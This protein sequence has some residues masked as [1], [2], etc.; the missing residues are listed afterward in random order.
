MIDLLIEAFSF[1]FFQRALVVGTLIAI[2][3]ALL[4]NFVVLRKE[5]IISHTI[6]HLALLGIAL[7]MIMNVN[8]ML[9]VFAVSL[10]GVFL[11]VFL[12][13]IQRFSHD[14]ILE[15]VAEMAIATATVLISVFG[16]YQGDLLQYLFG[17]ILALS[18]QDMWLAT[19]V[20]LLVLLFVYFFRT[21]LLQ[22]LFNEEL[23]KSV[24]VNNERINILFMMLL[25]LVVAVSL[26]IVGAVLIAAFLVIPANTAKGLAANFKMMMTYS[27]LIA[28]VG[29]VCGLLFSYIFNAPSGSMIIVVMGIIFILTTFLTRVRN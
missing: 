15:F 24:G 10:A 19:G 25:A 11:I 12:Q 23:A 13:N 1:S 29:T 5:V 17:D 8:L 20:T 3:C 28:L 2:T 22:S 18:R 7:G 16:S 26:K 6:S 27:V 9:G 21:R 4:G 14:S